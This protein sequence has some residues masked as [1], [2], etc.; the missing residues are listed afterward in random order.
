[1]NRCS[2]LLLSAIA[3]F[4]PGCDGSPT[5]PSDDP[6]AVV[7]VG[8]ETFRIRLDTPALQAAARAA[9]MGGSASIPNGRI[10]PGTDV[11]EGWSWHLTEV[12][13]AEITIELCD[14]S[15]SMVEEA[16]QAGEEFGG[17]RFCPW[18]ARVAAIE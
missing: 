18:S 17:G 11:N 6:V 16:V 8:D 2:C 9:L 13:F 15:P 1:M 10:L 4:A 7:R 12:A 5:D 14:G 3:L